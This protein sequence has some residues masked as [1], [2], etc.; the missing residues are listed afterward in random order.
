V[1]FQACLLVSLSF[2]G[3]ETDLGLGLLVEVEGRSTIIGSKVVA[4][5]RL[6]FVDFLLDLALHVVEGGCVMGMQRSS[7]RYYS[8]WT[9]NQWRQ[10]DW[11]TEGMLGH[12]GFGA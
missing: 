8:T 6:S 2:G 1:A 7:C 4:L 3:L 10:V 12:E 9:S 11:I 5:S